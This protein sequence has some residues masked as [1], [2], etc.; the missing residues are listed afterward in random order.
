MA[1]PPNSAING[2]FVPLT[3]GNRKN[4]PFPKFLKER[5]GRRGKP[6]N[7]RQQGRR[8]AGF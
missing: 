5:A 1:L 8:T 2:N 7:A 6:E 3:W 4:W